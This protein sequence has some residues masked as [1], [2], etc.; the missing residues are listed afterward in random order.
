MDLEEFELELIEGGA[1]KFEKEEEFLT[2]YTEFTD[3]GL[4]SSKLEELGIEPKNSEVQRIP[5]NTVELPVEDAKKI[6]NLIEKFEDDDDV[7]N[8]YHNLEITD[9]LIEEM[10]K[11]E[12]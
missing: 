6:L 3:F 5:L 10:E 11:E 9:E 8:V 12:A 4:M 2:V 7:Q 1:S